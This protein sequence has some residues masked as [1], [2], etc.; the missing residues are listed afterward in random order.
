ML[1]IPIKNSEK[2]TNPALC[3]ASAEKYIISEIKALNHYIGINL[4]HWQKE[5]KENLNR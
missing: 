2:C 3:L 1:Q 5:I 4:R